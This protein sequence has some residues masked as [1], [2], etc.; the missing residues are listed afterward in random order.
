[1][2]NYV[3]KAEDFLGDNPTLTKI[4][5]FIGFLTSGYITWEA[6]S[7]NSNS[8]WVWLAYTVVME[9]GKA[10]SYLRYVKTKCRKFFTMWLVLTFFSIAA[11]MAFMVIENNISENKTLTSSL[12]FQ[13]AK[14]KEARLKEQI[15]IKKNLLTK[16][17]EEKNNASSTL[18]ADKVDVSKKIDTYNTTI[19]NLQSQINAKNEDLQEAIFKKWVNTPDKL[20]SE[21]KQLTDNMNKTIAA[22]DKLNVNDGTVK[23]QSNIEQISKDIESLNAELNKID[24]TSL[25]QEKATSGFY[26][27]FQFLGLDTKKIEFVFTLAVTTT[28]EILICMLYSLSKTGSFPNFSPDPDGKLKIPEENLDNKKRTFRII[29]NEKNSGSLLPVKNKKHLGTKLTQDI[30]APN[31]LSQ[32]KNVIFLKSDPNQKRKSDPKSTSKNGSRLSE[33]DINN[34]L[35]F[36]KKMIAKNGLMPGRVDI[37][38]GLKLSERKCR[39][40]HDILKDRG[41]I[42]TGRGEDGIKRTWLSKK[43]KEA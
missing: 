15:S 35:D 23:A 20:R 12:S 7:A 25:P 17:I 33:N 5:Y 21:I 19:K 14:D 38:K 8:K 36:C 43:A 22:R 42:S 4:L 9:C 32:S 18:L 3:S 37:K 39:A 31:V 34:Y 1:M 41:L 11:S 24:Y 6:L 13:Q 28:F 27:L 26:A 10:I 40:I 16:A 2:K 29:K 30:T